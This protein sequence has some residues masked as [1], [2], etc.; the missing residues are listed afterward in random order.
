MPELLLLIPLAG[1]QETPPPGRGNPFGKTYKLSTLHLL[2][3]SCQR[4]GRPG[5]LSASDQRGAH[6]AGLPLGADGL[7]T[8]KGRGQSAPA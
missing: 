6:F 2:L 4:P 3:L 8:M 1:S 5:K 7:W